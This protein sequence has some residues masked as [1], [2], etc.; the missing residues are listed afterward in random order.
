M[1]DFMYR[2][3]LRTH[4]TWAKHIIFQRDTHCV[5]TTLCFDLNLTKF[6]TIYMKK[7]MPDLASTIEYQTNRIIN[8]DNPNLLDVVY[9]FYDNYV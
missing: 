4:V 6:N 7:R 9:L 5:Q 1:L 2:I 3:M 8:D